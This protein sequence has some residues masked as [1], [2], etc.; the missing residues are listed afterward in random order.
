[1][2]ARGNE[3]DGPTVL[4]ANVEPHFGEAVTQLL[5]RRGWRAQH[6]TAAREALHR[7]EELRP[8][9][10]VTGFDDGDVDGFEF[11]GAA[12]ELAAA[13]RGPHPEVVVCARQVAL[14]QLGPELQRLLGIDLVLARPCRLDAVERALRSLL[15]ERTGATVLPLEAGVEGDRRA[16]PPGDEGMVLAS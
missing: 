9:L 10:V 12:Y 15:A 5:Q 3:A 4:V 14:A 1:M 7:W 11:L 16:A 6:V 13:A 2:S 8:D